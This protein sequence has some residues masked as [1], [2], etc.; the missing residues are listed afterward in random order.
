MHRGIDKNYIN[1]FAEEWNENKLRRKPFSKKLKKKDEKKLR[2]KPSSKKLKK[3]DG[4][5]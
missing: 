1:E 2:W 4:K 3:K 5:K